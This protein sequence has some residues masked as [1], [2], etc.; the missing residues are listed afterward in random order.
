M[1]KHEIK[2]NDLREKARGMGYRVRDDFWSAP[3]E[4]VAFASNGAGPSKWPKSVRWFISFLLR[5]FTI[6][7][8]MHDWEF[9]N[10][11]GT[12]SSWLMVNYN[13][14]KNMELILDTKYRKWFQKIRYAFWYKR[15]IGAFIAVMTDDCF[16][17]WIESTGNVFPDSEEFKKVNK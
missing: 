13:M 4:R 9:E 10:S 14:L 5:R 8:V 16:N 12:I 7:F 11:D 2:I 17:T 3:I 6:V 15:A 1:T